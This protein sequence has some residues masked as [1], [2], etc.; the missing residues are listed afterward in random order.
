MKGRKLC[1]FMG[2]FWL[3][4]ICTILSDSVERQ[5]TVKVQVLE[6]QITMSEG[7]LVLK[8]YSAEI[9]SNGD[10]YEAGE[11]SEWETGL[12]AHVIPPE[13]YITEKDQVLLAT[14]PGD[15]ETI[16]YRTKELFPGTL[17]QKAVPYQEKEGLYLTLSK[18]KKPQLFSMTGKEPYMENLQKEE[19]GLLPEERLYSMTEM[20]NLSRTFLLLGLLV[21]LLVSTL[22][23]WIY[24]WKLSGN[25]KKNKIL[26][27]VNGGVLSLILLGIY[28]LAETIQMP[29]SL[30]PKE[31]ILDF[32]HYKETFG[33]ILGALEQLQQVG[34]AEAGQILESFQQ[35][36]QLGCLVTVL[37]ILACCAFVI[38]GKFINR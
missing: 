2:A 14:N 18:E 17:V 7:E 8:P 22:L 1:F 21:V 26:L 4:V 37:G 5:M 6:T 13:F 33:Q 3:L 9:L 31:N 28:K 27:L 15:G 11:G 16:L 34:N 19:L 30:L 25:V 10:L 32:G 12:R 36:L 29:S 38:V 24:S 35:N 23:I 20:E